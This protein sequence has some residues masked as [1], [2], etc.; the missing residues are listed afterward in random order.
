MMEKITDNR[1]KN[2]SFN[3]PR[4][5]PIRNS[6]DIWFWFWSV[7]VDF[8][9][10]LVHCA[11]HWKYD[12]SRCWSPGARSKQFKTNLL[13]RF[14][15]LR[16]HFYKNVL[17]S[18][19]RKIFFKSI[20][21]RN[22]TPYERCISRALKRFSSIICCAPHKNTEYQMWHACYYRFVCSLSTYG[23][24]T[25]VESIRYTETGRIL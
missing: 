24:I 6:Y 15:S 12:T 13:E 19:V 1:N 7:F 16:T 25:T 11:P 20:R 8:Q 5:N 21:I 14:R 23:S 9:L 4:Y 17:A 3:I 18:S 22:R 10:Y 2:C